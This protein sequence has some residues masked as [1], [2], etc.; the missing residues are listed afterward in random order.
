MA[1]IDWVK[2]KLENWALWAARSEAGGLGFASQSVILRGDAVDEQREA[3]LPVDEIEAGITDQA[4]SSLVALHKDLHETVVRYHI[5]GLSVVGL[6]R[7]LQVGESTVHARLG[8][9]DRLLAA[10]FSARSE[11]QKAVAALPRT[12]VSLGPLRRSAE[13]S[14]TS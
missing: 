5:N 3:R 7:E 11:R 2:N 8:S 6:A 14:F 1:R 13:K 10:W 9:A 4:V 12:P